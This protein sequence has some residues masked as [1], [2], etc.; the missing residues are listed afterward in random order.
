MS[1]LEEP[2]NGF[3]TRKNSRHGYEILSLQT[4]AACSGAE[5]EQELGKRCLREL[6]LLAPWKRIAEEI[7]I[8]PR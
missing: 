6:D 1:V 3:W 4:T 2:A 8:V 7:I 5:G